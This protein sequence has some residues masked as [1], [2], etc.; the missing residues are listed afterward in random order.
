MKHIVK[1][2]MVTFLLSSV[3]FVYGQA[4]VEKTKDE[5]VKVKSGGN[6]SNEKGGRDRMLV[7]SQVIRMHQ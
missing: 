5:T 1:L 7:D 3:G 6:L 2:L 4:P